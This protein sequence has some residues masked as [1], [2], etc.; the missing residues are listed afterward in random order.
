MFWG[1]FGVASFKQGG[2]RHGHREEAGDGLPGGGGADAVH[3][4]NRARRGRGEERE[5]LRASQ[6]GGHFAP[7]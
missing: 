6:V 1:S 7:P 3:V 2:A 5:C 4:V